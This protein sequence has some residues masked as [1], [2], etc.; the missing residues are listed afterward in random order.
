[1]PVTYLRIHNLT[2]ADLDEVRVEQP[3]TPGGSGTGEKID[4]GQVMADSHTEY[5]EL[6]AVFR[7]AHI[8]ARGPGVEFVLRPYDYVGEEPLPQG[9]YTYRLG[10]RQGRLTLDLEEDIST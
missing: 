6:R 8:E 3:G 1:M 5:R 10:S 7:F 2:G 9:R 4:F